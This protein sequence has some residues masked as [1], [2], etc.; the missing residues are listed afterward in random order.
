MIALASL[1]L[2]IIDQTGLELR[3][4]SASAPASSVGIKEMHYHTNLKRE[5]LK[6]IGHKRIKGKK[7][8]KKLQMDDNNRVC[9]SWTPFRQCDDY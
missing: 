6:G 5:F 9:I 7:Q 3:N 8:Q 4:L 2:S 1:D